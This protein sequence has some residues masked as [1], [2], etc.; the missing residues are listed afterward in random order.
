MILNFLGVN[1][2]PK[3]ET[4]TY[5]YPKF[6]DSKNYLDK[7]R[8]KIKK[9]TRS[10]LDIFEED[11]FSLIEELVF[12]LT[13]IKS[14]FLDGFLRGDLNSVDIFLES[15]E[16]LLDGYSNSIIKKITTIDN[17]IIIKY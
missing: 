9:L 7:I 14:E 8:N 6:L 2:R 13:D 16:Q 4:V 3:E 17:K 12:N 11:F 15:L 1:S 5:S 10:N